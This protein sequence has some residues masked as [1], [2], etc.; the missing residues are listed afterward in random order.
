MKRFIYLCLFTAFF[1]LIITLCFQ[2]IRNVGIALIII[3]LSV[4]IICIVIHCINKR[5]MK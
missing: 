5:D 2:P 1:G 3:G 4:A